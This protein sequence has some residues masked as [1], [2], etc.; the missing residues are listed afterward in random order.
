MATG[1]QTARAATV[2]TSARAV[3]APNRLSH[4][5]TLPMWLLA[6]SHRSQTPRQRQA[7]RRRTS[8]SGARGA[9]APRAAQV[10]SGSV[11]P[12]PSCPIH[13]GNGLARDTA[14]PYVSVAATSEALENTTAARGASTTSLAA[15]Q[16]VMDHKSPQR[17]GIHRRARAEDAPWLNQKARRPSKVGL[18]ACGG[19][20]RTET[21]RV[22]PHAA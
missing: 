4:S 22:R 21:Y 9:A 2:Q 10:K 12:N 11:R 19:V 7:P 17:G 20:G 3:L 5:K 8:R 1:R 14:I 15:L 6:A 16:S 13:G 18:R